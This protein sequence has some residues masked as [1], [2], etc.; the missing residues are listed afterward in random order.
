[1]PLGSNIHIVCLVAST[2]IFGVLFSL[3][4]FYRRFGRKTR[5]AVRTRFAKWALVG[6]MLMSVILSFTLSIIVLNNLAASNNS[7]ASALIVGFISP[8]ILAGAT[9]AL[10]IRS[11]D[12]K[13]LISIANWIYDSIDPEIERLTIEEVVRIVY[14]FKSQTDVQIK[15]KEV[16][17]FWISCHP[18]F[19]K[20]EKY[21]A[22]VEECSLKDDPIPVLVGFLL[23]T[24]ECDPEW[25]ERMI[26]DK[27][28]R[29]KAFAKAVGFSD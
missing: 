22:Q 19:D 18:R 25:L 2:L 7:L 1:M 16:A 11:K 26:L 17:I 21:Y 27:Q 3:L 8:A 15:L 20:P 13:S 4:R 9:A 10:G 14:R 6:Y 24:C 28:V 12:G 29:Q 5:Y 23:N